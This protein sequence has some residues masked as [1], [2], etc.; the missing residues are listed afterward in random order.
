M[1]RH[2][3]AELTDLKTNLLKMATMVENAIHQS[4]EALKK[5]DKVLAQKVIS[6]DKAI[7]ELELVIEEKIVDILALFQPLAGDLRF[8]AMAVHINGALERV[9][10]LTVNIS[11]RVIETTD[12][13][14]PKV[15][16]DISK[17]SDQAKIMIKKAIDAFVN[18][19]E[20]LAK[21]VILSDKES[22]KIR[23]DV[24][25]E[26]VRDHM[27]KDVA[28][29]SQAV[30]LVFVTRD[31]ERICDYAASIAEDIIYIIQAKVVKHH[32]ERL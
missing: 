6:D 29:A 2:L 28:S 32:P 13:P 5:H 24:I 7:D 20:N 22:N 18:R 9:A 8:I 23:T 17:L 21:E 4:I 12:S 14:L 27:T 31:L 1:E 26:L 30:A 16:N 10:D 11:Q 25:R 15:S 19:D 3:D